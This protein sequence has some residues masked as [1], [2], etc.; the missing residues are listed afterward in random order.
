MYRKYD[1]NTS[2]YPQQLHT[3]DQSDQSHRGV[4]RVSKM[5]AKLQFAVL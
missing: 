1:M 4:H 3:C 5:S 2:A